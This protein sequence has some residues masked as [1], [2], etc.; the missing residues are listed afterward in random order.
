MKP[1]KP[2]KV[3]SIEKETVI[4][5][6]EAEPT[7]SVSTLNPALL[8]RLQQLSQEYDGIQLIRSDCYGAEYEIPKSLV[9]IRKPRQISEELKTQ[10]SEHM[11]D[12]NASPA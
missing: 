10:L 5:F 12:T 9:S 3:P 7:A 1:V 6:N 2:D 11:R 8:R 4:I